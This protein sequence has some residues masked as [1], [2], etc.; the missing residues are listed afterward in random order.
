[1]MLSVW[2][3]AALAGAAAQDP[4]IRVDVK[5]VRVLATVTDGSRPVGDLTRDEFT[6]TDN[7]ARQEIALF[8]RS[9]EQT[10]SVAVLVDTSGSTAK[11]LKVEVESVQ[12]FLKAFLGEGNEKD[13][14]A[15]YSFNWQV[16]QESGFTRRMARLEAALSNLRGEAGTSLYDGIYLAAQDLA[17]RDGRKVMIVVTDGGDTTSRIKFHDA[18][19][20]A[21]RADGVIYPIV[22]VP[23][24]N[25]AGRNT[26]G[27]NALA[28]FAA[29]TGGQSFSVTAGAALDAA[30]GRILNDLRTQYLL[31]YYPR[32]VPLTRN[33]FHTLKLTVTRPGLQV[34]A[35]SG[36][37]GDA[38]PAA[39]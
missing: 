15:I 30:F 9:S 7:G 33:R 35:R 12:R 8:E 26:G 6:L 27:E 37:Y 21:H 23:V 4:V 34:R 13:S 20:A 22:V 2:L 36:Y 39:R 31:G 3:A 32:Q 11:D 25:P 16:K 1:M 29:G 19:E 28:Q 17:Q 38:D 10:L 24:K 5:L 14:V 18:M